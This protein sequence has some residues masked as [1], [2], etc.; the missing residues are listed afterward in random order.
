MERIELMMVD[1]LKDGVFEKDSAPVF[2]FFFPGTENEFLNFRVFKGSWE[3][4]HIEID[5]TGKLLFNGK[6][7]SSSN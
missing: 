4:A 3:K 6:E 7:I 1:R 2:P 5:P